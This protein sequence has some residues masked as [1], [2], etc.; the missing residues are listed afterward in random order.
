MYVHLWYHHTS[1]RVAQDVRSG[2]IMRGHEA[3]KVY[4]APFASAFCE[5]LFQREA[6]GAATHIT[7]WIDQT[8]WILDFKY[9]IY[10]IDISHIKASQN[11][12]TSPETW[13]W[14]CVEKPIMN[15]IALQSF[16]FLLMLLNSFFPGCNGVLPDFWQLVW[17]KALLSCYWGNCTI[18]YDIITYVK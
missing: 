14:R 17:M 3:R 18:D 13:N 6:L 2:R 10:R 16:I 5:R 1:V 7:G 12:I 15:F 8:V 4:P 11:H 9:D